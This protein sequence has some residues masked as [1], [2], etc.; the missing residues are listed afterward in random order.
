MLNR[1]FLDRSLTTNRHYFFIEQD[2]EYILGFSIGSDS[3][4]H[5]TLFTSFESLLKTY[6]FATSQNVPSIQV[7][8][9]AALFQGGMSLFACIEK[10]SK[11]FSNKRD[12]K[13]GVTNFSYL[14]SEGKIRKAVGTLNPSKIPHT[15]APK[16]AGKK[17]SP[18]VVSYFDFDRNAF[19]SYRADRFLC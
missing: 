13:K 18:L 16:G 2:G 6:F 14:N 8:L 3:F 11:V 17:K 7:E 12:L 4:L 19:R 10:A 9:I 1:I 5:A 15:A